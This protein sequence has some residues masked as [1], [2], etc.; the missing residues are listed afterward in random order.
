MKILQT[1]GA[2]SLATS[3]VLL[4]LLSTFNPV[5]DTVFANSV[6]EEQDSRVDH[7]N[8]LQ[9]ISYIGATGSF[10][11]NLHAIVRSTTIKQESATYYRMAFEGGITYPS[12]S[13]PTVALSEEVIV[14]RNES[15][16]LATDQPALKRTVAVINAGVDWASSH[17]LPENERVRIPVDLGNGLTS[18]V[19]MTF[20]SEPV[21]IGAGDDTK[22]VTIKT[23]PRRVSGRSGVF[24][25]QYKSIIIYSPSKDQLF[26]STSVFTA[27]SGSE[28]CR[29]E[30]Q[31]F[32]TATSGAN[33]R[34][35]LVDY[36][37]RLGSFINA[38][39]E[40]PMS[41]P[42]PPWV[43]EAM[44]A[45]ESLY[46]AGKAI[47]YQKTNWVFVSAILA[48]TTYSLMN[49]AWHVA[50]GESLVA[51][52][53]SAYPE[54]GSRLR[55]LDQEII[56]CSSR[57]VME[58][59][60]LQLDWTVSSESA[61]LGAK[62]V[63]I[64]PDAVPQPVAPPA[65]VTTAAGGSWLSTIL[66]VGGGAGAAIAAG[67]SS[68]G[69]GSGCAGNGLVDDYTVTVSSECME[70]SIPASDISFALS[71]N[72]NC[73]VTG[74]AVVFGLTMNTTPTT[75][76][77]NSTTLTIG[78]FSGTVVESANSFTGVPLGQIFPELTATIEAQIEF[79]LTG[80]EIQEII[81][82]CDSVAEYIAE[83]EMTWV[84]S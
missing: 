62:H 72:S 69:G 22:L 68:S 65:A 28:Q 83:L 24:E 13:T 57:T 12:L 80:P 14:T 61:E 53:T 15:G 44:S 59:S 41:A 81:D 17:A 74:S 60:Q 82:N 38:G 7:Y 84:R 25:C 49:Y 9:T 76:S 58:A 39:N 21:D 2:A 1:S 4:A 6:Q 40:K 48:N 3:A 19:V 36:K 29:L 73:S 42:P 50:T 27:S 52:V 30:E 20:D 56:A 47:V 46:C 78:S 11:Q 66:I 32:L 54:I 37:N 75:W 64:I 51:S 70:T 35:R 43:I 55:Y 67:S 63:T 79:A 71:L 33:P 26:Q 77:Y 5:Q 10:Q 16:R 18:H 45:R 34:Y 23:V 31:T 8:T